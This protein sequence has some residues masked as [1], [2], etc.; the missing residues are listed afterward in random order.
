MQRKYL[1][2]FAKH[3]VTVICKVLFSKYNV[4]A[5]MHRKIL[6]F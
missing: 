6:R 5:E 1:N 4:L 3:F 2:W